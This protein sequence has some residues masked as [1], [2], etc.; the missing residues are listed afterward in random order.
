MVSHRCYAPIESPCTSA[1]GCDCRCQYRSHVPQGCTCMRNTTCQTGGAL[2]V[3]T[4]YNARWTKHSFAV[5]EHIGRSGATCPLYVQTTNGA[6]RM[7][8]HKV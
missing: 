6:C 8:F 3:N 1:L 7:S 2:V 5:D 4:L